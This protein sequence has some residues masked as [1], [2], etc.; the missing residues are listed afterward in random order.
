MVE[1]EYQ[2]SSR[3]EPSLQTTNNGL[4]RG[5]STMMSMVEEQDQVEE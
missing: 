5:N 1:C 2:S 4:D 3:L